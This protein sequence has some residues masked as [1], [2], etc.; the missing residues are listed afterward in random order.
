MK[1]KCHFLHYGIG[2][3]A[4]S[5]LCVKG[6]TFC[7]ICIWKFDS[8]RFLLRKGIHILWVSRILPKHL[9]DILYPEFCAL[10]T[11]KFL[12]E[13][14]SAVLQKFG[15]YIQ[16][17]SI[18]TSLPHIIHKANENLISCFTSP[19]ACFWFRRMMEHSLLSKYSNRE[20]TYTLMKKSALLE[21]KNQ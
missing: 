10:Q 21:L 7:N 1:I 18:G 15:I 3:I 20:L 16:H 8:R 13:A 6:M 9:H 2:L 11:Q 19:S 14:I 17:F 4:Y 5:G 12:L